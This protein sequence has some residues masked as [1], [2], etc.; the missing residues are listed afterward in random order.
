LNSFGEHRN[1]DRSA[2]T[3]PT[4]SPTRRSTLA[5]VITGVAGSSRLVPEN[6]DSSQAIS[7]TTPAAASTGG[8]PP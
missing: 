6:P 7:T 5:C 8:S 3:S 2:E 4:A 1:P